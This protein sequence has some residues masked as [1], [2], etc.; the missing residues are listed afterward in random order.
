MRESEKK[1]VFTICV[2]CMFYKTLQISVF[3]VSL[4][5]SAAGRD[6]F[7]GTDL[8]RSIGWT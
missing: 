8:G 1:A 5:E 2:A 4:R 6:K 7:M 3:S